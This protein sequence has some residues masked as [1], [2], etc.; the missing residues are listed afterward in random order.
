VTDA[1]SASK[2]AVPI[3]AT[4]PIDQIREAVA[5]QRGGHIHGKVV[6]TLK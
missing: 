1:I 3:A 6:V 2:L 5:L 4:F